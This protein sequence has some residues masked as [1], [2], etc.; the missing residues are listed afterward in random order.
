MR[1]H[2]LS[3][4]RG[5][6]TTRLPLNYLYSPRHA[7]IA[8]QSNGVW[9]VGFTPFA[10]RML[11]ELVDHGFQVTTEAPVQADQIIGWIEGFKAISDLYC[12]V[13]GYFMEGNPALQ[14]QLLLISQAPYDAGWL[15]EVR[16]QP[17]PKS[18]DVYGYQKI[19]DQTIDRLQ[20]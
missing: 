20:K 8:P 6:F 17:Q 13:A 3:Y 7:W 14:E 2:Y 10:A 1:D 16:G 5:R 9:R 18:V 19:L 15:Y 11:G 4:Q 12:E